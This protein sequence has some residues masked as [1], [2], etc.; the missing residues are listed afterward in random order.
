MIIKLTVKKRK[1]REQ[2]EPVAAFDLYCVSV[3]NFI[4]LFLGGA[5]VAGIAAV[6][7]GGAGIAGIAA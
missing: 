4:L 1:R 6:L 7:F 3:Q 2:P 5:G